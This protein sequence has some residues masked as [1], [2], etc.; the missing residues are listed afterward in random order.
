[1]GCRCAGDKQVIAITFDVDWAS[2]VVVAD[3]LA[4]LNAANVQATF[5]ATHS[6]SLF[7]GIQGHEIGIHPNFLLAK[8][9]ESELDRLMNL[10]PQAKGVRCHSY[11]QNTQILDL[12][13]ERGLQYD[14]NSVMFGCH[15]IQPFKHWNGLVRVPV[16]W[17]DDINC[18]VGATWNPELLP[19]ANPNALYVFNF[20]P[21]HIYLNTEKLSRYKTAKP[22]YHD[23]IKLREFVNPESTDVGARVF[24]K[25]LLSLVK[26]KYSST[27]LIEIATPLIP[28]W[29][30]KC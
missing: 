17:E 3:T 27:T 26:G 7:N 24:L 22:Y 25:R 20:H 14:S 9:Y 19:L 18:L 4:L 15:N 11:Y 28:E 8:D 12:F 2:D 16:F 10:Y 13:V 30:M 21:I 29:R 23:P 1:M 6:T 5:F